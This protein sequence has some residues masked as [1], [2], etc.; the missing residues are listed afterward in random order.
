MPVENKSIQGCLTANYREDDAPSLEIEKPKPRTQEGFQVAEYAERMRSSDESPGFIFICLAA[1]TH[2]DIIRGKT[3]VLTKANGETFVASDPAKGTLWPVDTQ[4]QA[5]GGQQI[6]EVRIADDQYFAR[7]NDTFIAVDGDDAFYKAMLSAA[8]QCNSDTLT[9]DEVKNFRFGLADIIEKDADGLWQRWRNWYEGIDDAPVE[10]EKEIWYDVQETPEKA[11]SL[12]EDCK[13]CLKQLLSHFGE[14]KENELFLSGLSKIFPMLPLE[15]VLTAQ[16]LYSVITERKNLDLAILNSLTLASSWLAKG[17][18]LASTAQFIRNS[19]AEYIDEGQMTES[20]NHP[21]Y[22]HFFTALALL[23]IAGRHYWRNNNPM[24]QRSFLQ[25]PI[26]LERIFQRASLY[27]SQL[28]R[29]SLHATADCKMQIEDGSLYECASDPAYKQ[30]FKRD[31]WTCK[32]VAQSALTT[33]CSTQL[34]ADELR[35]TQNEGFLRVV[36]PIQGEAQDDPPIEIPAATSTGRKQ[37]Y[38]EMAPLMAPVVVAAGAQL[39]MA[40]NRNRWTPGVGVIAGAVS[41][42]G[43]AAGL[44]WGLYKFLSKSTKRV[45]HVNEPVPAIQEFEF[46]PKLP[47]AAPLTVAKPPQKPHSVVRDML[48]QGMRSQ[49]VQKS[50]VDPLSGMLDGSMKGYGLSGDEKKQRRQQSLSLAITTLLPTLTMEEC[51]ALYQGNGETSLTERFTATKGY[52]YVAVS[53]QKFQLWASNDETPYIIDDAG[54]LRFIRFNQNAE[55]W[56]YVDEIFNTGYSTANRENR[57]QY[58]MSIPPL[59]HITVD[60][61]RNMATLKTAAGKNITGVFIAGDFIPAWGSVKDDVIYTDKKSQARVIVKNDYGWEFERASSPMD[62]YVKIMLNE[63]KV[64]IS[65]PA[66]ENI[67]ATETDGVSMNRDSD[68]FVKNNYLYYS[69]VGIS[70]NTYSLWNDVNTIIEY[71]KGI[72]KLKNN[73]EVLRSLQN[74]VEKTPLG[75]FRIEA[76]ALTYITQNAIRR[77]FSSGFKVANGLYK[78]SRTSEVIGFIVNGAHFMVKKFSDNYLHLERSDGNQAIPLILRL[79]GNT[80]I[81]VRSEERKPHYKYKTIYSYYTMKPED[82]TPDYIFVKTEESLHRMLQKAIDSNSTIDSRTITK[83]LSKV[84]KFTLPVYWEDKKNLTTYFLYKSRFF[85]ATLVDATDPA[86]PTGLHCLRI[87]SRGDLFSKATPIAT[88][89]LENKGSLV[90]VKTQETALSEMLNISQKEAS[91]LIENRPWRS[92]NGMAAV[93]EAINEAKVTTDRITATLPSKVTV[94]QKRPPDT[95]HQR[96][97]A[98]TR[99]YPSR[100]SRKQLEFFKLTVDKTTLNDSE[101]KLQKTVNDIINFIREDIFKSLDNTLHY[102]HPSWPI[103]HNYLN[104][105]LDIHQHEYLADFANVWREYLQ[106]VDK[107]LNKNYVYLIHGKSINLTQDEKSSGAMVYISPYDMKIY[108]NMDKAETE[109]GA[110]IRLV[111]ELIRSIAHA[112]GLNRNYLDI[113][114]INGTYIPVKDALEEMS[115]SLRQ[116]KLTTEQLKNIQEI[117]KTYLKSIPAY[118]ANVNALVVPEV[119]AYLIKND[120]TFRA[121]L[122]RYS[123]SLVTLISLD[124]CY[125]LASEKKNTAIADAWRNKYGELRGQASAVVL[126]TTP[127]VE[128]TTAR[129]SSNAMIS[130]DSAGNHTAHKKGVKLFREELPESEPDLEKERRRGEVYIPGAHDKV[131]LPN[132]ETEQH[133]SETKTFIPEYG[134]VATIVIKGL[135]CLGDKKLTFSQ[136]LRDIGKALQKPFI[137]NTLAHQQIYH[138]DVLQKDCPSPEEVHWHTETADVF[139]TVFTTLM[140]LIPVFWPVFFLQ[141]VAGP[142]LQQLA[143]DLEGRDV[144]AKER[145]NLYLNA[146]LQAMTLGMIKASTLKGSQRLKAFPPL[147]IKG[148][149]PGRPGEVPAEKPIEGSTETPE[150]VFYKRFKSFKNGKEE[151]EVDGVTYPLLITEDEQNLMISDA[152]GRYHFVRFNQWNEK[153]EITDRTLDDTYSRINQQKY[154]KSLLELSAD[155]T[156]ELGENDV[157]TITTPGGSDIKGVFVG[158]D[159]IPAYLRHFDDKVIA[160]TYTE[161]VPEEDQRI[162]IQSQYGWEFEASSANMDN[163]L[164]LLLES[165]KILHT[166]IAEDN[167]G[168]MDKNNGISRDEFGQ[169]YIKR[170]HKY[171]KVE[172]TDNNNYK[173]KDYETA[174]IKFSNGY[175]SLQ[176]ADDIVFTLENTPVQD[177]SFF[178][179]SA[180]LRHLYKNALTSINS[181]PHPLGKGIYEDNSHLQTGLLIDNTQF[182]ATKF[183]NNELHIQYKPELNKQNDIKLWSS[184]RVWYL[185]REATE[186]APIEYVQCRPARAPGLGSFCL[187]SDVTPE[188]KLHRLLR[189]S[190]GDVP[191]PDDLEIVRKFTIPYL[192]QSKSTKGYYFR[193]HNKYFNAEIIDEDNISN[194]TGYPCVKLLGGS[195]FYNSKATITTIVSVHDENPMKLIDMPTFIAN[196]LT[197]NIDEALEHIR[198][199]PYIGVEGIY[200]LKSVTTDTRLSGKLYVEMPDD[201]GIINEPV[202]PISD[203]N[204]QDAAEKALYSREVLSNADYIF[205]VHDLTPPPKVRDP[206]LSEAL[207]LVDDTINYLEQHLLPSVLDY[208]RPDDFNNPLVEDYLKEILDNHSPVFISDVEAS[209][210]SRIDSVLKGLRKRKVKLISVMSKSKNEH[211]QYERTTDRIA[212]IHPNNNEYMF[213]NI[214]MIDIGENAQHATIQDL[215]GAILHELIKSTGTTMH[216]IDLPMNNGIYINIKDALKHFQDT[217]ES[218][219]LPSDYASNLDKLILRYQTKSPTYNAH[220]DLFSDI[221]KNGKKFSY[222][223]E[224]DSAFKFQCIANSDDFMSLITQDIYYWGEANSLDSTRLHSWLKQYG[225]RR[226]M[227]VTEPTVASSTDSTASAWLEVGALSKFTPTW[228]GEFYAVEGKNKLYVTSDDKL[229]LSYDHEYYELNF[230]GKSGRVITLGSENDLR[231]VYYYDPDTGD[232]SPILSR[233]NFYEIVEYHSNLDLYEFRTPGSD[234]SGIYKYDKS[235]KQLVPTGATRIIPMFGQVTRI[236]FPDF[237]IYHFPNSSPDLYLQGYGQLLDSFYTVPPN[238]KVA[239]YAGKG[240]NLNLYRNSIDHLLEGRLPKREIRLSGESIDDYTIWSFNSL[241]QSYYYLARKFNKNVIQITADS[242]SSERL[243]QGVSNVFPDKKM[244]LHLFMGRSSA[245]VHLPTKWIEPGEDKTPSDLAPST[246]QQ[247]F[248][249]KTIPPGSITQFVPLPTNINYLSRGTLDIFEKELFEGKYSKWSYDVY[250]GLD[251]SSDAGKQIPPYILETRK[252][253]FSAITETISTI[254][255]AFMKLTDPEYDTV[256]EQYLS[257]AV[258]N[259][260]AAVIDQVRSRL[261]A[262]ALR[263]RGL[264]KESLAKN[265]DNIVIV[266]SKLTKDPKNPEIYKSHVD[267]G[268]DLE[269]AYVIQ[270]DRSNTI[271]IVNDQ[272]I[273]IKSVPEQYRDQAVQ[274][275][276]NTMIHEHSHLSVSS[277]DAAYIFD[278]STEQ[279]DSQYIFK[280]IKNLIE[281]EGIEGNEIAD[282]FM[283]RL[284]RHLNIDPLDGPAANQLIKDNPALMVNIVLENADSLSLY[285]PHIA[286]LELPGQAP[287]TRRVAGYNPPSFS[288]FLIKLFVATA[289]KTDV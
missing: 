187:R 98:I 42:A 11:V 87:F 272:F 50:V 18:I 69:A 105:A 27:W 118:S 62:D 55:S 260:D 96:Q 68:F 4:P 110:Q 28:G 267:F 23:A 164:A 41:V 168:A 158:I 65:D 264:V 252:Q 104:E 25:I 244:Q 57:K 139:D 78:D 95:A 223:L 43:A 191:A 189:K 67:G 5:K 137:E 156:I 127:S 32:N 174:E 284:Y 146:I 255:Q 218:G 89:V 54:K 121:W 275:Q 242:T 120:P 133:N 277:I 31:L 2:P 29:M 37:T 20:N 227:I 155:S 283:A 26:Y 35:R 82:T 235:M 77:E 60:K 188:K 91:L 257:Y 273:N 237:N 144:S 178:L 289:L 135:E 80:W 157:F 170:N 233:T 66:K 140:T 190:S 45:P 17:N 169:T 64:Y 245:E 197:G 143:D 184:N 138:L 209:L 265:Y 222:M 203:A 249:G 141:T 179:E 238:I 128:T 6:A 36:R 53:G 81:R 122:I 234:V 74:T 86:N 194:P 193:Y 22:D 248:S 285:L 129:Q 3:L 211:V 34:A 221:T 232:I 150:E 175:F 224:N 250:R 46:D 204:L 199:T 258:D 215:K 47:F 279:K 177:G 247:H 228:S 10:P 84:N 239:F 113:R 132:Q 171:Y 166:N 85:P 220:P 271:Y 256:V 148:R 1:A 73:T 288:T 152:K 282:K 145:L 151:I 72:F 63:Q 165:G 269:V 192:Y 107:G 163:N 33:Q 136:E 198:N 38:I 97:S 14:V 40:V 226:G 94:K 212:F 99:L 287:R 8:K 159:F 216:I 61:V 76:E 173:I 206:Y 123:A 58:R 286:G 79:D 48:K 205:S 182:V 268:Q 100:I 51:R 196:R 114:K 44:G 75:E 167:I 15:I 274:L 219:T 276:I 262:V 56:E 176:S 102:T 208:L 21:S 117:S 251:T 112:E 101:Q 186:E 183:V 147:I 119:L 253:V 103:I 229:L 161:S 185:R 225:M 195:D 153:W 214:D 142:F 70:T 116:N 124:A 240:S 88:I 241:S 134:E 115:A 217:M 246:S 231:Q 106:K 236:E 213:I 52:I 207:M 210:N 93:E 108:I 230:I 160:Y 9:N 109:N 254:D 162:L 202:E 200:T 149:A 16:N 266:S 83:S 30:R 7:V 39:P 243:L 125:L 154:R 59:S 180:A 126:A 24:P 259:T 90:E 49:A 92:L 111:T 19:V 280:K 130:A 281:T 270:G 181:V 13:R 201:I 263:I 278:E 131:F 261:Q 172:S 71:D 12:T